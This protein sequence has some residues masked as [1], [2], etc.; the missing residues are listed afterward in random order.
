MIDRRRFF[1]KQQTRLCGRR[2]QSRLCQ[3]DIIRVRKKKD[4]VVDGK[5]QS[6]TTLVNSTTG[7]ASSAILMMVVCVLGRP[8][9]K[10]RFIS[11]VCFCASTTLLQKNTR[12]KSLLRVKF[13]SFSF[14]VVPFLS[15]LSLSPRGPL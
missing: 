6:R 15:F 12:E 10:E 8:S 13:E 9:F 3:N 1:P 11:A 5:S 14:V 4:S 7:F 2:R